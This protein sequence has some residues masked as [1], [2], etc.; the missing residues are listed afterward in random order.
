MLEKTSSLEIPKAFINL[1]IPTILIRNR[2][3]EE[4]IR[5]TIS[6]NIHPQILLKEK[7]G[8]FFP[9]ALSEVYIGMQLQNL[10]LI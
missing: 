6:K 8:V 5:F 9:N 2:K 3:R 4:G 10:Q 1:P 7:F